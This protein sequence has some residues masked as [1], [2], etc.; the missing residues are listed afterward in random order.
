MTNEKSNTKDKSA[1]SVEFKDQYNA[2]ALKLLYWNSQI[3]GN[4]NTDRRFV[5]IPI[6]SY[7]ELMRII[8]SLNNA[9]QRITLDLDSDYDAKMPTVV[10]DLL[11]LQRELLPNEEAEFLDKLLFD[12]NGEFEK[13]G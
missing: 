9:A 11:Y 7:A 12:E 5:T 2:K 6:S 13:A 10:S 3:K 8:D 4:Q 1:I